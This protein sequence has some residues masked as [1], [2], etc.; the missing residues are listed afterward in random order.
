MFLETRTDIRNPVCCRNLIKKH[1]LAKLIEGHPAIL[2]Q[3]H[4]QMFLAAKEAIGYVTLVLPYSTKPFLNNQRI[5]ELANL[6]E[7]V[8][9]NN[10][11]NTLLLGNHLWKLQYLVLFSIFLCYCQIMT[12]HRRISMSLAKRLRS[13]LGI[14]AN[15]ILDYA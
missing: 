15:I 14:D 1:H 13:K 10:E 2:E 6:L 9:T 4:H 7:F 5:I 8:N 11:V 12:G 3:F